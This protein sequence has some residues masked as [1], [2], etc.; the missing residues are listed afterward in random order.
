[1][2]LGMIGAWVVIVLVALLGS[3][4]ALLAT[5]GGIRHVP[6]PRERDL[7]VKGAIAFWLLAAAYVLTLWLVPRD[8]TYLLLVPYALVGAVIARECAQGP[9][10]MRREQPVT[11]T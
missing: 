6:G 1:M 3:A 10:P 4:G 8:Y 9:F 5:C 11:R 2:G 7:A